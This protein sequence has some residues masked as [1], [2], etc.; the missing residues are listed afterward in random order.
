MKRELEQLEL[1][2]HLFGGNAPFVEDLYEQYLE[3]PNQVDAG[4]RAYFDK[5]Q[6]QPGN[7]GR[8]IPRAPIEESFRQL[9]RQPRTMAVHAAVA[10]DSV[11]RK[12]VE[13][14]RMMQAYRLLGSRNATLDPLCRMDTAYV[15]ELDPKFYGFTETDMALQFGTNIKS[16]ERASLAEVMAF[17]KQTY[18]G[19]IGLEFMH[20]TN[21][22]TR[23]WVLEWFEERRSTPSFNA[24]QKLRIFKQVTAAETLEQYLHKKNTLGKSA[25]RW[26]AAIR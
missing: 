19:N 14:L 12:Q 24:E 1:N 18:C 15:E 17:A 16:M 21:S 10:D 6:Q 8:D 5:L 23:K 4:W 9:A 7:S 3:D 2:S 11:S 22:E 20:I 26:K 25:S 13:V